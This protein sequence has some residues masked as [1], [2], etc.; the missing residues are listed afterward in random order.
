MISSHLWVLVFVIIQA[1]HLNCIWGFIK[2]QDALRILHPQK[3]RHFEDP[4]KHLCVSLQV[5][6]N[7]KPLVRVRA[8]GFK[9]VPKLRHFSRLAD[10]KQRAKLRGGI[11][12]YTPERFSPWGTKGPSLGGWV[13]WTSRHR[14]GVYV[15]PYFHQ[16]FQ[17]PKMEVRFHT[18]IKAVWIRLMDTGVSPPLK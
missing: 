17:V 9:W 1:S 5:H 13:I 18:Y 4:Q 16:T 6:E 15:H 7:P 14:H 8:R 10:T 2:N 12:N 3:W 11:D